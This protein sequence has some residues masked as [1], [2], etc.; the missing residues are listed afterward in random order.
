MRSPRY[1]MMRAPLAMGAAANTP[2]PCTGEL[3][4]SMSAELVIGGPPLV[5]W[6]WSNAGFFALGFF[7]LA[8]VFLVFFIC[9][10]LYGDGRLDCGMVLVIHQLKVFELVIEYRGWPARQSE[11]RQCQ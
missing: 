10:F 11:L 9:P 6:D 3:R 1:S 8:F 4:T 2:R 5:G 7:A